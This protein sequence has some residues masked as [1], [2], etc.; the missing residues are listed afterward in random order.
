MEVNISS[1]SLMKNEFH[2]LIKSRHSTR[3]YLDREVEPEILR[4]ILDTARFAPSSTNMQ[5]WEVLVLTGKAKK[6]L[7][8]RLLAAYDQQT[9]SDPH[10]HAYLEEWVEPYK[11]RRLSCGMALY[12]A[13]RIERGD[14]PARQA[15]ARKNFEAF[16][17]PAVMIFY[18]DDFLKPGSILDMGLFLQT[19]MLSA[20]SMGLATCPEASL[21]AWP[22]I[23][24]KEFQIPKGKRLITGLAIGYEDAAAPVN[25]YRTERDEVNHFTRFLAD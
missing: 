21:V 12:D 13:V 9:P 6:R 3:A 18:Q 17:A 14:R 5:P 22:E 1:W 4:E 24:R 2:E 20:Q 16:G 8:Q 15:Q 11:T 25:G 7:D 10:L 19:V 23:L